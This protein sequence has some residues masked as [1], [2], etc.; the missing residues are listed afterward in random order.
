MQSRICSSPQT[1]DRPRRTTSR[2]VL[3]YLFLC[4]YADLRSP[5]DLRR[6]GQTRAVA[7]L[8][9]LIVNV[10]T[11]WDRRAKPAAATSAQM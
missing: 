4:V 7:V 9:S 10:V 2:P 11:I 6:F 8:A 3:T 5:A 1:I